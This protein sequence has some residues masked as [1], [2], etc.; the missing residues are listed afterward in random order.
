[1]TVVMPPHSLAINAAN[2]TLSMAML[3]RIVLA[4]ALAGLL[5]G[6][7]FT[8]IQ[9][10][11]VIPILLEAEGYEAVATGIDTTAQRNEWQPENGWQRTLS[12]AITNLV[13][14]IGF[15][16]LL[17]AAMCLRD[18][19]AG[20]RTG[21]C[22][23]MGGYA[24]FFVAP[25]LGLAPELPGTEAAQLTDRQIWWWLTTILSAAGLSLL[26]LARLWVVKIL[27]MALL[28]VPYFIG[29]PQPQWHSSTAPAELTHAFIVATAIANAAFWLSLGSL[30][31]LFYRK[32]A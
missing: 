30:L 9:Q 21:L 27:G 29:P 6:V 20:W 10:I 12:T 15:A 26:V 25:S 24:V 28:G 5:A 18:G 1:M 23:G 14:A 32:M 13:V 17:G 8:A 16:L 3:R 2:P 4:A 7:L 31:G 19:T 11:Q 22:W